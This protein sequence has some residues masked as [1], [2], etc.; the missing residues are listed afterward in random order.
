MQKLVEK[1]EFENGKFPIE[2]EVE[3]NL[4]N[5]N[6]DERT[7]F[8]NEPGFKTGKVVLQK[9]NLYEAGIE[10]ITRGRTEKSDLSDVYLVSL[11]TGSVYYQKGEKIG[12]RLYYTLTNELKA[13]IGI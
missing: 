12:N 5:I 13:E 2:G 3:I 10:T 6:I 1:Y 11:S 7:Q 9:I 4:N 8:A